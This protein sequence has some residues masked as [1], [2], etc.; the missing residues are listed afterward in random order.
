MTKTIDST[1]LDSWLN[2][3]VHELETADY[4]TALEECKQPISQ[5]LADIFTRQES[6]QGVAWPPHAP[7]T[8]KRYGPHPLLILSGTMLG[9]VTGDGEGHIEQVQPRELTWGTDLIYANTQNYGRDRIPPR[10]FMYFTEEASN[11]CADIL[12]DHTET[13]VVGALL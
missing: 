2:N 8:T 12:M 11:A 7:Y 13:I 6:A 3:L 4:S 5:G 9:A 1:E 10:E